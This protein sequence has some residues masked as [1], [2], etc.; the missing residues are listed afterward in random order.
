MG[1]VL[2]LTKNIISLEQDNKE[3]L[4]WELWRGTKSSAKSRNLKFELN[5][6]QHKQIILQNCYYCGDEPKIRNRKKFIENELRANGVD[7]I[8]SSIGYILE[9]C[10]PCCFTCNEMK[11]HHNVGDFLSHIEKIVEHCNLDDND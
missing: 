2:D 9:N 8:D 7:R 5:K 6:E 1:I 4:Y 3:S 10:V 11:W